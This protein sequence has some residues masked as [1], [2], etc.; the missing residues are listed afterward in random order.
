MASFPEQLKQQRR[1]RR[2]SQLDLSLEAEV[3]GRHIAFLE[4]GR[5]KPS[6]DMVLRLAEALQ[7]P[8][9]ERNAMLLSAG[10]A[11]EFAERGLDDEALAP[12]RE[13]MSRLLQSQEP[14]PALVLDHRW[15]IIEANRAASLLFQQVLARPDRSLLAFVNETPGYRETI[16]N[17]TEIAPAM[18]RRL[19][20]DRR[21]ASADAAFDR[22]L[23]VFE[24]LV[25]ETCGEAE[26]PLKDALFVSPVLRVG[27]ARLS[28]FSTIAYFGAPRDVAIS[29]L[30]IELFFPLDE[31]TEAFFRQL[32]GAQPI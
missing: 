30:Q 7:T 18:L 10:F 31:A 27:E 12:A 16:E 11:P 32:A 1:E 14:Y 21:W 13:A 26:A 2:M 23:A 29:E 19:K 9:S 4:T 22:E 8:L 28:L 5:S 17:W 25:R 15:R 24:A 3:S 20:L 6:R